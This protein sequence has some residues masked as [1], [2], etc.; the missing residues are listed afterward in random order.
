MTEIYHHKR[1]LDLKVTKYTD[2]GE[3]FCEKRVPMKIAG[4]ERKEDSGN[5]NYGK[6]LFFS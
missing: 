3:W 6:W 2:R 4:A 5:W 1:G